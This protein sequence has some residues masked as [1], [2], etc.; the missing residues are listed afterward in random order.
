M[1]KIL[2]Y[3]LISFLFISC[4]KEEASDP[5]ASSSKTRSFYLGFTPWL[6]AATTASERTTYNYI[7]NQ[8][9][10]VAH[11][12]QQGIPFDDASTFPNFTN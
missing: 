8:G 4:A 1:K 3:L 12:F 7:N 9:D 11:H 2:I 6:Y 10:L 5:I